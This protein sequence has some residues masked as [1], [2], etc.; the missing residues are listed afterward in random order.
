MIYTNGYPAVAGSERLSRFDLVIDGTHFVVSGEHAPSDGVWSGPVNS[1]LVAALTQ[2]KI[3]MVTAEG[4]PVVS[5]ALKGAGQAIES[6][7]KSCLP[8]ADGTRKP[9]RM[10]MLIAQACAGEYS[11]DPGTE[12]TGLIDNDDFPDSVIFWGGVRCKNPER[13]RGFFCGAANCQ[14]SVLLTQTPQTQDLLAPK[15]EV[16]RIASGRSELR[17]YGC[18]TGQNDCPTVWRWNGKRME[19]K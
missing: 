7:L 19:P 13:G 8:A 6:A 12:M 15:V 5:Y 4:Q 11:L 3:A 2:G 1:D 14:V 18:R 10:R 16:H 17:T 9:V